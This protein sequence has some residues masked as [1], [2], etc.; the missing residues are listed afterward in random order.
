M[1]IAMGAGHLADWATWT[2]PESL[3]QRTIILCPRLR[4]QEIAEGLSDLQIQHHGRCCVPSNYSATRVTSWEKEKRA[5]NTTFL[6]D[7][8]RCKLAV[9][10]PLTRATFKEAGRM[11]S[12]GKSTRA[13]NTW[14]SGGALQRSQDRCLHLPAEAADSATRPGHSQMRGAGTSESRRGEQKRTRLWCLASQRASQPHRSDG[15]RRRVSNKSWNLRGRC[16]KCR[17][18]H[19]KEYLYFRVIVFSI[20]VHWCPLP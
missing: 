10:Q 17:F 7:R 9:T 3:M 2:G 12:V 6:L 5:A 18:S 11:R 13:T 8:Q 19:A 15:L 4:G 1:L 20:T 16:Y 14:A